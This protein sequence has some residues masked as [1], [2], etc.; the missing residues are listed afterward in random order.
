LAVFAVVLIGLSIGLRRD[1]KDVR[2]ELADIL[3]EEIEVLRGDLRQDVTVAARAIHRQS[4][5]RLQALHETVEG[6]RQTV[7][8]LRGQVETP[9]YEHVEAQSQGIGHTGA[10][11]YV[12]APVPARPAGHAPVGQ[13][14]G[15]AEVG[16]G[17]PQV[18]TAGTPPVMG[19]GVVRHT[20]TVQVTTRHTIVDP[21]LDG[22]GVHGT[23]YSGTTYGHAADPGAGRPG[24][25]WGEPDGESWTDQ[26]LRERYDSPG[27]SEPWLDDP[28]ESR[29]SRHY[30]RD[31]DDLGDG[32]PAG[33]GQRSRVA[34]PDERW[35]AVDRKS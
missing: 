7:E 11:R 8:M 16:Q 2:E 31:D 12:S 32:P 13:P 25:D 26:R 30:E 15:R 5:E 14:H 19:G 34:P 10:H 33:G 23:V 20:E 21:A 22:T 29:R 1:A 4:G 27:A 17:H 3:Y 24:G 9:R 6:L 18:G 28:R 35:A